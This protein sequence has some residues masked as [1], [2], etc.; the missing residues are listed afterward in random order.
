MASRATW[1]PVRQDGLFGFE[2]V[3]HIREDGWPELMRKLL[4]RLVQE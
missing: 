2:N 3:V 4:D 1:D